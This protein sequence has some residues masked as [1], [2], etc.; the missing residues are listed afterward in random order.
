MT[1]EKC[2][3][4]RAK[5]ISLLPVL[6][7]LGPWLAITANATAL[8]KNGF[9]LSGSLV[10]AGEI[11]Q[12]GPPKDG[13]PAIDKPKFIPAGEAGFLRDRDRVI[14]VF[15]NDI[16][17]AY[18]IRIL[19]WHEVVNDKFG[20]EAVLVSYCPLCRTGMVFSTQGIDVAF[21]FG[22]SGLLYNSDVLL[23][24]RQTNSLWSQILG[25]AISGP[26][27]DVSIPLLPSS[28]T[29]WREWR[30]RHPDTL[31]LSRDTGFRRSYSQSPYLDY[32]GSG[33]LMF[34]VK[35]RNRAYRNK[36]L[37]L[38]VSL[39][40]RHK[41][42]PFKELRRQGLQRFSDELA[43]NPLTI[44]WLEQDKTARVFDADG[45][46]IPS[47]LAYWFAWYAFHPDTLIFTAAERKRK[48]K[49]VRP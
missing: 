5:R 44:E 22:V 9:D 2:A 38:G 35:E 49:A 27:K 46:E 16:A 28:H 25:K 47:V 39:N 18:P 45:N 41:A 15:R 10:P 36:E 48:E 30:A 42:F 24:D 33:R 4:Q 32:A 21:T 6:V 13:I 20:D 11:H 34:P 29:T 7:V 12:G 23:Y 14:G 17:K 31:V 43:G 1:K 40:D 8:T 37:V 26:M 3:G 19:D